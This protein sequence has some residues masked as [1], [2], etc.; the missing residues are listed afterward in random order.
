V[1]RTLFT[2]E[3]CQSIVQVINL[4]GE[5]YRVRREQFFG[6]ASRV[7]VFEL[8]A[9]NTKSGNGLKVNSVRQRTPS[10][11]TER[12]GTEHIQCLFD[13]LPEELSQEQRERAVEFLMRNGE[14]FSKGEF[15]IGRTHLVE[16]KIET[17]G[18]RPVRQA[19]RRHLIAYLPL[20]DEYVQEMQDNGIIKPRIGFEWVSNIVLVRK[21]DG[22]LRYC[23]DYS[24]LNA[25]TMKANYLLPRIDACH[26][27]LRGNTYFSSLDMRSGYWQVPVREQDVDKTCFVTRKG[28]FGFRVLPF[29]LYNAPS[30][31]QRLVDMALTGLT[32]EVCL[33]YLNDL[34]IFSST[35][36]QHI[37]RLQKV[38]DRLVATGLKLKPSK[39]ALFQK[40]V[41]FLGS[42]VSDA[43]IEPDPEKVQAVAQWPTLTM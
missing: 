20:I 43:G 35:F 28:I 1:A 37:E 19:L 41:K 3:D 9:Q 16:H 26:D 2:A 6:T 33:A 36:E 34:I 11:G 32:W 8:G 7:E 13:G 10:E 29:G 15:D 40:R 25:V 23:I 38:F 31:F 42:I 30:T 4:T 14:V 12:S 21:K 18:S 24:G 17:D 5:P 39:C 27:S 22:A